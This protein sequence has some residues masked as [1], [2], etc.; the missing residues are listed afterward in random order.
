MK[1]NRIDKNLVI[2]HIASIYDLEVDKIKSYS[3]EPIVVEARWVIIYCL[4]MYGF[5]FSE[6]G[7]IMKLHHTSAMYAYK[8]LVDNATKETTEQ[9]STILHNLN[10]LAGN[11]PLNLTMKEKQL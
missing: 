5:T 7:R 9:L 1:L 8:K 4:R 2:T 6:I 11:D 10:G 3:R